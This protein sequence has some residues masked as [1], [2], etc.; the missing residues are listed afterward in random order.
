[1]IRPFETHS[2]TDR[3]VRGLWWV[4][5]GADLLAAE[6]C[7]IV[8]AMD[9][10][11][12]S[13]QLAPLEA[14]PAP[15]HE[16]VA[17]SVARQPF[18]L[19]A[20]FEDL[21]GFY[22]AVVL[23]HRVERGLP[24]RVAGR[25]LG[26]L[27]LLFEA[28]G[29]RHHW[30]LAVKF[31]LFLPGL[32]PEPGES[33]VGP[34]VRDRLHRKVARLRDHQVPLPGRDEASECLTTWLPLQSAALVRGRLFYPAQMDWRARQPVVDLSPG[35]ECG[36]W[37][38]VEALRD[39]LPDASGYAWLER[40]QWLAPIDARID[41]VEVFDRDG[42]IRSADAMGAEWPDDHPRSRVMVGLDADGM[43]VHRGFVVSTGWPGE[44]L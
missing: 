37:C 34:Q 28:A 25:T 8:P 32:E 31:Y 26:E 43:E 11:E 12:L 29:T 15:L 9:R 5:T 23:G 2:F 7:P 27:D 13:S 19:G 21:V 40:F 44:F 33:F 1:M 4:L 16:F 18:R 17:G 41:P 30:E 10:S 39:A 36:W 3:T 38:H 20:Y 24:I 14:D 22:V 35:H 6:C 42:L